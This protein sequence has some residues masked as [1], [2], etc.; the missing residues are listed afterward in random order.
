[1]T[2]IEQLNDTI[3]SLRI[4]IDKLEDENSRL[5]GELRTTE[6]RLRSAKFR[7]TEELEPRIN[8]DK[9]AYDTWASSPNRMG[10]DE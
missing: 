4:K 7:I 5:R 6:S 10:G 8:Q 1:M 2:N 9:K 3:E